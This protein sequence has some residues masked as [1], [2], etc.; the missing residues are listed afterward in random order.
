MEHNNC[1]FCQIIKRESPASIVY[2]DPNSLAFLDIHPVNPG[3]TLLVPKKHFDR[4]AETSDDA[5]QYL[6]PA[7]KKV[8]IALQEALS[9]EGF[10]IIINNGATA[11]EIVSHTHIHLIPRFKTDN[12]KHWPGQDYIQGEAKSVAAKIKTCLG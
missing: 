8:G 9:A 2:E 1:I 11:G 3:H 7:A 6:L 4:I 12:L 10:N 5:L